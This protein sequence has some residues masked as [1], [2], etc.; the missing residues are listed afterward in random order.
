MSQK[1]FTNHNSIEITFVTC[2][3]R[4][5]EGPSKELQQANISHG[6]SHGL[7]LFHWLCFS[8]SSACLPRN[9]PCR[10]PEVLSCLFCAAVVSTMLYIF[11]LNI[12]W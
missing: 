4:N 6:D 7:S 2:M 5:S 10:R 9:V 1:N 8:H 12:L 3:N 11:V